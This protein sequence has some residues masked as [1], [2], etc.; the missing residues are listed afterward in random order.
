MP[1]A[2]REGGSPAPEVC[3]ETAGTAEDDEDAFFRMPFGRGCDADGG[4]GGKLVVSGIISTLI[5][6]VYVRLAVDYMGACWLVANKRS[7]TGPRSEIGR[8]HV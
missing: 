3:E 6:L 8:A 1:E 4:N 7:W 2:D 5:M